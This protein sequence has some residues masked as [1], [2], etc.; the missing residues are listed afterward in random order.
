ME[1]MSDE[2][3]VQR[4]RRPVT[5]L[6]V[7]D[8]FEWATADLGRPTLDYKARFAPD[9]ID[10]FR[11]GY[12][13]LECWEPH[14]S[15]FPERCSLCGYEMRDRQAADF[16][17]KFKGVERDPRSKLIQRELDALDDKHERNFHQT[18]SGVVIPRSL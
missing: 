1:K 15:P 5:S 18:K 6:S 3:I 8:T 4:W 10:R 11:L 14:E 16:A 12:C 13:C 7:D 17:R 2:Q 9:Q